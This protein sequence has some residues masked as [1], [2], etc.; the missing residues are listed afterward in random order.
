MTEGF[1]AGRVFD[2]A[3]ADAFSGAF[4]GFF[5]GAPVGDFA[6]FFA[7]EFAPVRGAFPFSAILSVRLIA[8]SFERI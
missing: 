6:G 8:R 2:C 7:I 5:A 1:A 4:A 3:F